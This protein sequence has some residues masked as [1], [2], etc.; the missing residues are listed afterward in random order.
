[1]G[2]Y[3]D[4][5][6][7]LKTPKVIAQLTHLYGKRDGML[8]AQ[9]TRYTRLIKK[10]E[11]LFGAMKGVEI[12]SAPG[13]VEVG[14]NHTDHNKGRVLTAAVNLDAV[15][16]VSERTDLA[17]NI[18]SDGYA[19]VTLSL[20]SLDKVPGEEGTTYALVRGVAA[21]MQSLGYPIG[22]FDAVINS[23]VLSGSGLSSS[24]SF[25]VLICA[26][27]D[28]LYG[29]WQVPPAVRAKIGQYA[30]NE[31]FGKPSGL[32]DQM[33]SSLGGLVAID[34]KTADPA[35]KTID[36]DFAVEGYTVVVVNTG[37]SHDDLIADYAAIPNEMQAVAAYFGEDVLRKVR[38][39]QLYQELA[40]LRQHVPDRAILRAM[41]YFDE[42]ARVQKQV[43]ALEAND[44][45]AFCQLIIDSGRSS[46]MYLQNVYSK[47]EMQQ[48][49]LGLALAEHM[50]WGKGAWRV[51]GG[52]F[53]GTTLN[54]VPTTQ[55]PAFVEQMEAVFGPQSCH[56]LDIRPEGAACLNCKK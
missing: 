20:E 9:T 42:N 35:V 56:L 7:A 31:Y 23:T 55:I 5:I 28:K 43:K 47:A 15:A 17:V 6:R 36:Y 41:H 33:A 32:M 49:S 37:G 11:E 25:E 10:H 3:S 12:V 2:L 50:L 54:F 18:H 38:P 8:V 26:I 48:I 21:R 51:H 30:E 13:R 44:M 29:G 27:F 52:G 53:A 16:V 22:G 4:L 34:F 1:M 14:G 46:F 24:A 40:A 45:K 19:P 39:E